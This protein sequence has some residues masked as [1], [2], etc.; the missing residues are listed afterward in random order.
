MAGREQGMARAPCELAAASS[1]RAAK[2]GPL[3]AVD[4][5]EHARV[6]GD[7]GEAIGLNFE[8]RTALRADVEAV[9]ARSRPASL[10]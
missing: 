5:L 6:N 1:G 9:L 7:Q 10:M 8:E 3:G 4:C 2:P